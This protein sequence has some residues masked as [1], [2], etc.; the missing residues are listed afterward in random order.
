LT[1]GFIRS[2]NRS[3]ESVSGDR[4]SLVVALV[5]P[6]TKSV[7]DI[8]CRGRE[9]R[10]HLPSNVS[11]VGMDLFPPA[12]VIASAEEPLP[13][14]DDSFESVVLADVLEHL[15]DPHAALDEA[16]RVARCSVVVL[17]PNLFT[18]LARLYF[19]GL[20]RMPTKKY[21]FGPIPEQDRHRW[22]LNF[23]Q[24]A[25]FTTGRATL[26]GWCVTRE[27]AYV[28][29]FR[30]WSARFAYQ[31]A[32]VIGGPNLWSW[33]YAARLEPRSGTDTSSDAV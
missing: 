32:R 17:L 5:G 18:L 26:S 13:F 22:L 33:A 29:P 1:S 15:E 21:T 6:E 31:A 14:E 30:R 3:V 24:A 27:Y 9:L 4:W 16:M 10:A 7:L 20:G 28:L 8:G 25:C 11:Y 12:D 2:L 19:A 23:E